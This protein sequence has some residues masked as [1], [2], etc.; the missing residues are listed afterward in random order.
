MSRETN[1]LRY[2]RVLVVDDN[3]TNRQIL[4]H[5]LLAW[6]M[7]PDCAAG[8]KEALKVM[9]D[10]A[11]AGD[12]YA[13]A[14]LDFQMPEMDGLTLARAIQSDPLIGVTRLVMLT[15]HGQLLTPMELK[16]FGI[17]SCLIKPVKQS[18]LFDCMTNAM[19][20]MAVQ[21]AFP[22]GVALA[23]AAIP[24]QVSPPLQ[25]MR[26]LLAEDNIVNQTVA[27]AQLRKLGYRAQAVANGLEVVKALE[28]VSYDVILMDCQ[29]PELDGYE[30]TKTIRKR[31]QAFDGC[32]PWKRPV[33]IIAM[34]AHAMQG[35][36]E[37]CLAAGMD[38]YLSKP[39]RTI[40]L[41]ETLERLKR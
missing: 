3:T 22:K 17:D 14:L 15:S 35:E 5:Q 18:R 24:I 16:E 32:C 38:D 31:E 21:T 19:D 6:K 36:R 12:P 11:S 33:H 39:V 20:R 37:K 41:Q 2:L 28:Q 10:A 29:M 27:L 13:L 30:A 25:K 26:I 1:K 4:R 40:D 7:K 9:R 23:T 8:G 34:T